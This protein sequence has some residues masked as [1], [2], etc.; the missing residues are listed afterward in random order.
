[1]G[2]MERGREKEG[3][4]LCERARAHARGDAL[5]VGGFPLGS[6]MMKWEEI[7]FAGWLVGGLCL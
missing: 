5:A 2:V 6:M 4:Y 3:T 1:M 7:H